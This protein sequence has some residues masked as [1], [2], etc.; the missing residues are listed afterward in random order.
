MGPRGDQLHGLGIVAVGATHRIDHFAAVLVPGAGEEFQLAVPGD[1]PGHIRPLA[2]PAG[3]RLGAG[4]TFGRI[5]R[6]GTQADRLILQHVVVPAG[7]AVILG[8]GITRPVDDQARFQIPQ[9][10]YEG[11]A[12]FG[13]HVGGVLAGIMPAPFGRAHLECFDF[14]RGGDSRLIRLVFPDGHGQKQHG[15]NG[16]HRYG[17]H[18]LIFLH[19]VP[20]GGYLMSCSRKLFWVAA[21]LRMRP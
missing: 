11:V 9:N 12:F 14:R 6:A 16:E 20:P 1:Q 8:K 5:G 17:R 21:R 13:L 18:N 15:H 10:V 19:I 7:P 4:N 2:G 3:G